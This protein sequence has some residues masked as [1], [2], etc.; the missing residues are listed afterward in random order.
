[1]IGG[2]LT[3]YVARRLGA[4]LVLLLL[5]SFVVFT[6]QYL[7]PGSVEQVMLGPRSSS[8]E[9]R[10]AIRHA[11]HLD[12]PFLVQ[13]GLWLEGAVRLD[14]GDSIRTSEPVAGAIANRFGLSLQLGLYAFV[15]T[16][17]VGLPL[18][19]LAAAKR[20]SAVDRAVSGLTVVGVSAPAFATGIVLL[21]VFAVLLGWFPAFGEGGGVGDR[22]LHLTLPAVT[23]ATSVMAYLVKFTRTATATAL[24]QDYVM[25]ARARGL[26][27]RAVLVSY[28]LRN[29]LIPIV[30]AG[31]MILT[32]VLT[33]T[34]LVE[35]TFALPGLGSLLIESVRFRDLPM[36]QG[37]TML[38][39]ASVI[40]VNLLTDLVIML[41]DPRI[42]AGSTGASA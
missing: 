15:L 23:L 13:Y 8:P 39:A 37:I 41:V 30:T 42:R 33:G 28:A 36:V 35:V 4:L 25:F 27:A 40:L 14:F 6:L 24:E 38:V 20:R 2:D 17:V 29:A 5:F 31:G 22:L 26:P 10:A 18:G 3:R 19:V 1:V 7:A 12:R 34:V 16:L 32:T 9:L 21:Y 11:Y